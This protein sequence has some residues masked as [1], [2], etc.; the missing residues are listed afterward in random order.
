MRLLY[1]LGAAVA[2]SA[3]TLAPRQET[4]NAH[5]AI[6]NF[7]PED[8]IA[9]L[10]LAG[11]ANLTEYEEAALKSKAK[12]GGCSL[13]NVSIR[14]DWAHMFASERKAYIS[15]VLCLMKNPSKVDPTLYPGAKSRFD[16]FIVVHANYSRSI[17]GTGNFLTWHRYFTFVYEQAL[18]KE[19][20]Y[21][22][23]QPYWN[24]GTWAHDPAK[25][26]VFDGSDTSL[27]S[28]GSFVAHN[29][30]VAGRGAIWVPS[31]K[32][33]GCI[34]SGPFK[35]MANN[36]GPMQ[37]T[38]DGV[39]AN[40][41]GF[42]AYNPR[43]LKRDISPYASSTWT[44]TPQIITLV[45]TRGVKAFQDNINGDFAAGN[46]GIHSAGHY[47]IGGDPGSDFFQSPG[48]PVFYLHHAMVD[49]TYWIHQ[50]LNLPGSLTDLDGTLTVFNN[51]PTRN[52]TLDDLLGMGPLAPEIKIRDAMSSLGGPFCYIYL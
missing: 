43:C 31:G 48:D 51:P 16:D 42:Y 10:G 11:L 26:P 14:R 23:A 12:R 3:G 52:T 49:R 44:T 18:K 6:E 25:S 32:G 22:G 1:V 38:M 29:G 50:N 46:L 45:S 36:M 15:S 8:D 7:T 19:C 5:E 34:K 13:L 30:S 35:N 28:D 9:R 47:T 20:G 4:A 2:V 17:H 24:W 21:K 33:G 40:P 41:N 39:V 37:P 27:G